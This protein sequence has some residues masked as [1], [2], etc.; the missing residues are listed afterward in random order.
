MHVMC[1]LTRGRGGRRRRAPAGRHRA[2]SDTWTNGVRYTLRNKKC[3]THSIPSLAP[4]GARPTLA[5]FQRRRAVPN[6][7][8]SPIDLFGLL[9]L[10]NPFMASVESKHG[11]RAAEA[12]SWL[13]L[14]TAHRAWRDASGAA[15]RGAEE[16][17]P[18]CFAL[19]FTSAGT[20]SQET[21]LQRTARWRHS[22][23]CDGRV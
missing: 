12:L 17:P 1:P 18:P 19:S 15:V 10:P 7:S 2:L 11:R 21:S 9:Q 14:G 3:Y 8:H 23:P 5:R 6:P 20:R 22:S 4:G 16:A 13:S